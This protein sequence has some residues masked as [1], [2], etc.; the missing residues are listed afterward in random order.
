[1]KKVD[2]TPATT[3]NSITSDPSD[4]ESLVLAISRLAKEKKATE[5]DYEALGFAKGRDYAIQASY[6]DILYVAEGFW[7]FNEDDFAVTGKVFGDPVL[8]E[9]FSEALR[10]DPYIFLCDLQDDYDPDINDLGNI[11]IK[12]FIDGVRQFWSEV[13]DSVIEKQMESNIDGGAISRELFSKEKLNMDILYSRKDAIED[14]FLIDI[15]ARYPDIAVIYKTN[16]CVTDRVWEIVEK[17]ADNPKTASSREGILWDILWMSTQMLNPMTL[18]FPVCI[19]G[20][21]GQEQFTFKLAMRFE[22]N[23]EV[24]VTILLPAEDTHDRPRLF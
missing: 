7:P 12:A 19:N 16:V 4:Q 2:S 13:E 9:V 8:G 6:L 17:S 1:M 5:D 20:V 3:G 21:E 15:T 23:G 10:N 11:F 14:G 22:S 24:V 18:T